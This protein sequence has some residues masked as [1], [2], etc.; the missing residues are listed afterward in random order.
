MSRESLLLLSL[1][2]KG[3]RAEQG[4]RNSS[5]PLGGF[6]PPPHIC[7]GGKKAE[8][9]NAGNDEVEEEEEEEGTMMRALE[10]S[11][12][13]FLSLLQGLLRF[14]L[15]HPSRWPQRNDNS[16]PKRTSTPFVSQ[17]T[18]ESTKAL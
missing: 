4:H 15:F 17:T 2:C 8:A 12:G 13:L 18:K 16:A 14:F 10:G 6:S 3:V 11:V 1:L 9:K 7:L 5:L